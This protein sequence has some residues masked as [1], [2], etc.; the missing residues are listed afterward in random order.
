M[1][2]IKNTI[3]G[4]ITGDRELLL[5]AKKTALADKV[6]QLTKLL[7]DACLAADEGRLLPDDVSRWWA[8]RI[9]QD[10]KRKRRERKKIA[11][12]IMD[13]AKLGRLHLVNPSQV[14]RLAELSA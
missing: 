3:T 14:R 9:K 8:D 10:E 6:M 7:S 5:K 12:E 11:K 4:S 13:F 1:I 2:N